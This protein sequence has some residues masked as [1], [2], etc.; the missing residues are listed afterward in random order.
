MSHNPRHR[1]DNWWPMDSLREREEEHERERQQLLARQ[2]EALG[3]I[4]PR[5]QHPGRGGH[6]DHRH[7]GAEGFALVKMMEIQDDEHRRLCAEFAAPAPQLPPLPVLL[8]SRAERLA[9][10]SLRASLAPILIPRMTVTYEDRA[11]L[12]ELPGL[13]EAPFAIRNRARFP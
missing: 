7:Q 1:R 12:P 2:A 9:A 3:Y 10:R 6:R 5:C 11:P 13:L 8:P 4:R